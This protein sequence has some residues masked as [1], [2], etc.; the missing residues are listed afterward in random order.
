MPILIFCFSG[1]IKISLPFAIF[2]FFA[3]ALLD[4]GRGYLSL[5]LNVSESKTFLT[6][7]RFTSNLLSSN[8]SSSS[9]YSDSLLGFKSPRAFLF[10]L[11][12][13]TSSKSERPSLFHVKASPSFIFGNYEFLKL[14]ILVLAKILVDKG[15]WSAYAVVWSILWCIF[16]IRLRIHAPP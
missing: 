10:F 7:K 3:F 1:W 15:T 14:P 9:S 11:S 13:L 6:F 12:A 2:R 8:L 4:L 5:T 16:S